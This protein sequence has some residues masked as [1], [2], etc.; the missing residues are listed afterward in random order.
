[1][2]FG[3]W[4]ASYLGGLDGRNTP[5]TVVDRRISKSATHTCCYDKFMAALASAMGRKVAIGAKDRQCEAVGAPSVTATVPVATG[6]ARLTLKSP[7]LALQR[8]L[9]HFPRQYDSKKLLFE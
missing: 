5:N 9:C 1:M 3:Q 6:G 2:R 8:T 4:A 7:Y